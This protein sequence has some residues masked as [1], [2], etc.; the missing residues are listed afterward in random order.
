MADYKLVF[1]TNISHEF[2]T[3][4]TLIQAALERIECSRE[5]STERASAMALM[6]KSVGRMLRLVNELLEFRKAE[7]GKLTL[8]LEQAN[9]VK[10]L[11]NHYDMFR[12]SAKS[13]NMNYRF[14]SAVPSLDMPVDCGK[15]DKIVYN[16]LSNAFKYTPMGGTVLLKAELD[17]SNRRN[18][19]DKRGQRSIG[20]KA[21]ER[22]HN[23]CH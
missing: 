10:L 13:K 8:Q 14:E 12:E 5:N 18:R 7:K 21:D 3:P 19:S 2:R 4:L 11:Q 23:P 22:P 9:V 20:N 17:D 16:L 15:L 6:R 1:F